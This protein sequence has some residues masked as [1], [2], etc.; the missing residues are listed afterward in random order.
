M[1]P[2]EP[3]ADLAVGMV[4]TFDVRNYGD[5]LF[6]LIA[7]AALERRDRRIRV[8]PFSV[9][10]QP[11]SSWPFE[12]RP[13]DELIGSL[14]TLSAMLIGGGQI[15]RFDKAYPIPAPENAGLPY[16]YWLT[17]AV[18]AALAGKPVIW[19]AVGASTGW[20]HAPWHDELLRRALA[21]SYF[22]GVRDAVSRDD[23]SALAPDADIRLLPDT[24]FG[25]SRLWPFAA[26][27]SEFK[28]WRTA[29]GLKGRYIVVQASKVLRRHGATVEW[30]M[31]E[32]GGIDAVLLPI[33]WC[34]DDRAEAFPPLKGRILPSREWLHPALISEIIARSAFVLASSLHASITALSY[35]VPAALA[36]RSA[37]RKYGM[38]DAFDGI[39]A[40]DKRPDLSGLVRRG[41]QVEQQVVDCA[42][43]LDCYWDA[44]M[45]VVLHP[46]LRQRDVSRNLMLSCIARECVDQ[47]Q[48]GALRT[49]GIALR[50]SLAGYF[51][52]QRA[53]VRRRLSA[54]SARSDGLRGR[55]AR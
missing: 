12:V 51:P 36:P 22:V 39:A 7:A 6:P 23:L 49:W 24:A 50:E 21:A 5:L 33:C 53:A 37:D 14:S 45:N 26:E 29:L 25:L 13:L 2:S 40:I 48:L 16:A 30:L 52:D 28:S 54:M 47:R 55:S 1:C 18:L 8:V 17:P 43:R 32:M 31:T 4:G 42:D 3:I 10:G 11:A 9:T 15:L 38:L 46:P 41:R 27:S 35:G 44:V 34:H 20:P 19:N